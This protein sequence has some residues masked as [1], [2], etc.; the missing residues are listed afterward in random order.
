M[1]D[2]SM[3]NNKYTYKLKLIRKEISY[4]IKNIMDLFNIHQNTVLAWLKDGL[5]KIDTIRPI[6]IHGS[7]LYDF[8]KKRQD[9]RKKPCRPH[10][11]Y[12][13]K[14]REPKTS[15]DNAIRI[16]FG[17]PKQLMLIGK[18]TTCGTKTYKSGSMARQALYSEIFNVE[19]PHT[20]QL[21]EQ[22]K[23]PLNS[24]LKGNTKNETI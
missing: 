20:D 5:P 6:L 18:C 16:E 1:K 4:S 13:L 7:E 12:C 10:Q 15:Q 21:V 23:A 9:D 14:C 3:K 19:L 24:D 2:V 22:S 11:L 8:L 17:G